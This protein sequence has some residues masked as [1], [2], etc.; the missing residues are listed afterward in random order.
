MAPRTQ[1]EQTLAAIW[2]EVLRIPRVG[3]QDDFFALGGHSLLATQVISRVQVRLEREL[4]LRTL[5]EHPTVEQF[6]KAVDDAA[7]KAALRA[8]IAPVNRAA[9]R[10]KKV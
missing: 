6:A 10:A 9:F 2:S 5:F 1:T 4:P 8:K 3:I 7:P